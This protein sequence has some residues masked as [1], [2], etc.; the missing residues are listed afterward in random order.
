MTNDEKE[1]ID[2][3]PYE[4]MFRMNRFAP[5][6]DHMMKGDTGKYFMKVMNQKRKAVGPEEHTRISKQI[7]W[8]D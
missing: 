3:M 8:G 7:G 4:I 6:G 5:I 2:G 1:V